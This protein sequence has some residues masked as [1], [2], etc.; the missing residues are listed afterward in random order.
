MVFVESSRMRAIIVEQDY[1]ISSQVDEI[2]GEVKRV[3]EREKES[4]ERQEKRTPDVANY[5]RRK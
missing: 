1:Y 4:K 5:F 3:R 2:E